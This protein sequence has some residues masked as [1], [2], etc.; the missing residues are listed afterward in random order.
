MNYKIGIKQVIVL[1][2]ISLIW[3][4]QNCISKL[5]PPSC[6]YY[7]SCS[8]YAKQAFLK[9]GLFLG[10]YLTI[11]RLL[12]CHPFHL[13]GIDEVPDHVSFFKIQS[14]SEM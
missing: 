14:K 7:P 3:I 13:G 4:Y 2:A 1:P 12:R 5:I 8:E 11:N 9:H 6:I 10:L